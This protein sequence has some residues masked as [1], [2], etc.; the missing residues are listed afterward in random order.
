MEATAR[1][2]QRSTAPA[3]FVHFGG[4][5]TVA[6]DGMGN[7]AA[8][9]VRVDV[10]GGGDHD[11]NIPRIRCGEVGEVVERIVRTELDRLKSDGGGIEDD[12]DQ[13]RGAFPEGVEAPGGQW[14]K[15]AR[16]H[17][18]R[19]RGHGRPPGVERRGGGGPLQETP[20]IAAGCDG[21][22]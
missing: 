13:H 16:I 21:H 12:T 9:H 6:V 18:Q 19:T 8:P 1:R 15:K 22:F 5:C 2:P 17:R 4:G 14:A 11:Q 10:G 7:R 3:P 20:S